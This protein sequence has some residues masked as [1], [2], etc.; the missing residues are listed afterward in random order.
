LKV[1]LF[2]GAGELHA[3]SCDG[4]GT[5]LPED[6]GPWEMLR[7]VELQDDAPDERE[8]ISLIGEHGFC[9]FE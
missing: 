3:L 4:E 9:C 5:N 2:A 8:A 6:L 7:A 1:W